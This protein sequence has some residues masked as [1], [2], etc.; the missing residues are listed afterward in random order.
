MNNAYLAGFVSGILACLLGMHYATQTKDLQNDAFYGGWAKII[1]GVMVPLG[2]VW[3][4]FGHFDISLFAAP[5]LL[6][7]FFCGESFIF[8][9]LLKLLDE[10]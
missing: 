7:A 10:L 9:Q 4:I 1:A 8:R 5:A 6:L 3:L 2:I